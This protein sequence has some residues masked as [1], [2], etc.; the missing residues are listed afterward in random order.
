M[1]P[2]TKVLMSFIFATMLASGNAERMPHSEVGGQD[3][4]PENTEQLAM[5][6]TSLR[7]EVAPFLR[8]LPPK[9]DV[10]KRK[11]L[12]GEDWVKRFEV[13][14]RSRTK[15]VARPAWEKVGL[16]VSQWKQTTVPEW[17]YTE[18]YAKT[19][20][21]C[22]LWYRKTFKAAQ[23]PDG[24]RVVLVLEG[25]DW[26][27]EVWLNGHKFGGHGVYI[28]PFRF[29]ITDVLSE[30][31]E[32]TLAV[33]VIDGP[34]YG[35]PAANW[36]LFP[37]P[38]AKEQRYVRDRSK[39]LVGLRR[40][41]LHI[42]GGYGIFGEVYLETTG[43]S[44][45]SELLVRG[46]PA[47]E[48]AVVQ[49]FSDT[50]GTAP[51]TIKVELLPDNFEGKS[52]SQTVPFE[53]GKGIARRI[54][55]VKMPDARRWS[56]ETPWLYRCRVSL[57]DATGSVIDTHDALFGHRT[58]EMVSAAKP[59]EGFEEGTLL[60]NGEP[61]ILRGTNIQG[62]N[63]L[64]FWGESKTL[65]DLL[66]LLKAA[67]FNAIR[68]CQHMQL[69]EVRELLDRFGIMSQQDVGSRYPTRRES[70]A[71]V[72]A[73]LIK[74]SGVASRVLYNNPGV[75]LLSLSNETEFDPTEMVESALKGD[76]ERLLVP[77]SGR[78]N[79][80]HPHQFPKWVS[81]EYYTWHHTYAIN[82][83]AWKGKLPES[84]RC[85]VLDSIHPYWGWYPEKGQLH[86]WCRIQV[87]GRMLQVGEYGSEALD[88]YQ[89]M[90]D[91]PAS[92]GKT[93]ARD[94]DVL[95]GHVQVKKDDI[96]QVVGFRGKHPSSLEEYIEASQT[97][98]YDQLAEMTKAWR[99]SPNRI[100]AYFQ[101]HFIDVIPANW[102]KSIVSHDL[103]PKR[104]YFAMAQANQPLV[105]L[106]R[107]LPGGNA[108][109]LWVANHKTNTYKNCQIDWTASSEGRVVAEGRKKVDVPNSGAVL[110]GIA[111]LSHINTSVKVVDIRL[112]CRDS[113]GKQLS[114]YVQEMYIHAWRTSGALI[115]PFRKDTAAWIEAETAASDTNPM[116]NVDLSKSS[117]T[118]AGKG[119][120]VQPAFHPELP[121]SAEWEGALSSM[122]EKCE[123]WVR[124]AGDTPVDIRLHIDAKPMGTFVLDATA[125]W[126]YEEGELAW[127][128]IPLPASLAGNLVSERNDVLESGD[129]R[130]KIR[131][132]FL[133]RVNVNLDCIALVSSELKQPAGTRA[134]KLSSLEQ[135]TLYS[136]Y[137]SFQEMHAATN[138]ILPPLHALT[139]GSKFHWFGYYLHDQVD[140]SGR[141]LLAAEVD[142]EN[143]LPKPTDAIKLGMIDLQDNN[144][145]IELG[146]SRAWSWQQQCFL[147][148]RPS[149]DTEAVWNDR[150]GN[151]AVAR[152][153]DIKSRKMRTL[154]KAVDEAISPD[155][156]WALCSDFSRTWR[157]S[158][159]YGY[160][161]IE[162]NST[163]VASPKDAGIWRMNMNTG[164]TKLLVSLADLKKHPS[165]TGA[166]DRYCYVAHFDWLPDGKRFSAY[167]RSHWTV[168]THV[169][170]FAADGSDMRLLSATGASHW[171]WRDNSNVLIWTID[172]GYQIYR[173][174]GSGEARSLVWKA[175]NGHQTYIPGTRNEWIV[176]DTY[177]QGSKRE[178]I[179]YLFHIP[180]HRFIPLARLVSPNVYKG[181]WRCDLHPSLSRDGKKVFIQSPHAGNGRQIYM[182]DMAEIIR[183]ATDNY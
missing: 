135:D 151:V 138:S 9:L 180:T 35:E 29:D 111:D 92:W 3:T 41:D 124:H 38:P 40:G 10:R 52:Y 46:Y 101:F 87:P 43:S 161:G 149:S 58:I 74:A 57:L 19:P 51:S 171:A 181:H 88:G 75:V 126:G 59:K 102:P 98:Q 109:E 34:I 71:K 12:S 82:K 65:Q 176:T 96:R 129:R 115:F 145:W 62:L 127:S 1:K 136:S 174:D 170:T 42:G 32:N 68:S 132:D 141:Y 99:L 48:K 97:Y 100:A 20:A 26:E 130:M 144:K 121:C 79:K 53:S 103:T 83:D 24:K 21:S 5:R 66:L 73:G 164:E 94:A 47:R 175:P 76:S 80:I 17:L 56:P 22:I 28:E 89:T 177:P 167:Y 139:G 116:L 131:F 153:L 64:S 166:E 143:R 14:P 160:P 172:K 122:P 84:M 104:A 110:A 158:P 147:Q 25:V 18:Q 7:A 45:I 67:H 27:A 133:G 72:R 156:K 55:N 123:L 78:L 30:S 108:M 44:A 120:S 128:A 173:D 146:E 13:A 95:W 85:Q 39:S 112:V 54:V 77:V 105:P 61:L 86:N 163:K 8:S 113:K 168:P 118:S 36:A 157:A 140:S 137:H 182:V 50:A 11:P 2:K 183:T 114:T 31:G 33:R 155:G 49:V 107:L 106:P 148:W 162:N 90:K 91:Y 152:V 125:G 169:Y 154:P 15:G 150:E 119:L 69:P 134:V 60:L 16:D 81:K 4:A 70:P 23:I 37:M 179:L 6:M 165:N 63:A 93:P 117:V 159:G 178:Q 142:F